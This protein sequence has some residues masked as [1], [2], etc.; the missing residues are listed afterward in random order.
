MKRRFFSCIVLAITFAMSIL[1]GCTAGTKDAVNSEW[2]ESFKKAN[3]GAQGTCLLYADE[4]RA[5]LYDLP[6]LI[7]YDLKAKKIINTLDFADIGIQNLQGDGAYSIYITKDADTIL[8]EQADKK[9]RCSY[10]IKAGKLNKNL[11]E[12]E[13]LFTPENYYNSYVDS[14]DLPNNA[15]VM[16]GEGV[17]LS[18]QKYVYISNQS[19]DGQ[20]EGL[21]I[22]ILS[23]ETP[24][25]IS[26][27]Q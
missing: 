14:I 15:P 3:E 25:A 6:G 9:N 11:G 16:S 17:Q 18:D 4:D 8:F 26:I 2:M 24:D 27:F 1:A 10:E 21:Q 22:V 13:K 20:L 19:S 23:G 12:S 7:V 5:I